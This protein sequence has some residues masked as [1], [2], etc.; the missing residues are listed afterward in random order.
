[1]TNAV[2][3]TAEQKSKSTFKSAAWQ[4][5]AGAWQLVSDLWED[6]YFIR[7]QGRKFLSQFP[8]EPNEKFTDRLNDSVLINNFRECIETMAGTVFRTN[9]QPAEVSPALAKLFTDIDLIG[10][11]LHKFCVDAFAL[12][13]RDGN[14]AIH[15]DAPPSDPKSIS[16]ADRKDH[17]PFWKFYQAS[18]LINQQHQVVNGNRVLSK[19]T[20]ESQAVEPDGEYGEK[21]VTK[22]LILSIGAWKELTRDGED[23]EFIQTG[24]GKTGLNFIPLVTFADFGASPLLIA[25]AMLNILHYNKT[26]DFDNWC[27]YACGPEKVYQYDSKQDAEHAEEYRKKNI[28]SPSTARLF[29][30]QN[31]KVYFAEVSGAGLELARNRYQDIEKEMARIGVGML[32]PSEVSPRSATEVLDSAGKSQSKLAK[33]TRDF[34]NMIEKALYITGQ[35]FNSIIPNTVDL[36]EQ[37]VSKLRLKIDYDRLT[38]SAD[39]LRLYGD[40]VDNGRLSLRTFLEMLKNAPE[41]PDTFSVE[42]ELKRISDQTAITFDEET[43][44]DD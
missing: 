35:V 2:T 38:F 36:S 27:Q 43:L 3:A 14:G 1:M 32:M 21:I 40:L 10:N 17:R 6:S 33:Y 19:V 31:A 11:S 44:T 12:C 34:E 9:P 24:E 29:W 37:E 5:Q 18:Q 39:V 41:I 20:I 42:D 30:G 25:L 23:K 26:S 22:H 8:K 13:L 15:I 4:R 16:A 28:H 7:E